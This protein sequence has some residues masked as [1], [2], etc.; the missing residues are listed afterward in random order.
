MGNIFAMV[1]TDIEAY[2]IDQQIDD[3]HYVENRM[4]DTIFFDKRCTAVDE[5]KFNV[6]IEDITSSG[7]K[8]NYIDDRTQ[9]K[10]AQSDPFF[11][12]DITQIQHS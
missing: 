2:Y 5:L 12:I 11:Y 4:K 7:R 8:N 6:G 1:I 9:D 3:D 10:K